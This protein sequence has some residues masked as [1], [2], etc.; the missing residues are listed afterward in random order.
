[1]YSHNK[2]IENFSV[3]LLEKNKEYVENR[4]KW[5]DQE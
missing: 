4:Q 1:M 5:E 2:N 3:E